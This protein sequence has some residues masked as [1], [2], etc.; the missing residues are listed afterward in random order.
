MKLW[1]NYILA[2]SVAEAVQALAE[3]GGN[4]KPVAGGTDLLLELQQGRQNPV[5]T[6]VDVSAI[7]DLQRLEVRGAQLFVGAGVPVARI[8]EHPL[9]R[10]HAPA[11]VEACGLIGGPQ[12]RNTATLGGNVA[13]ALPAADGMIALAAM[14]AVAEVAGPGTLRLVPLLQLFRGLGKNVLTENHEILV[15][16]YL[17]LRQKGNASVFSRIMRPQGVALPILNMAI[18][19]Q[20]SGGMIDCIRLAVGP[21]GPTP[22]RALAVEEFLY[23]QPYTPAIVDQAVDLIRSSLKF[24]TNPRRATAEYRQHLVGVLLIEVLEKAWQRA[25]ELE[26]I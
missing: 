23:R 7:P 26:A 12:V 19:L 2:A 14:D 22:Q 1:S 8:V 20:R 5:H 24:R 25:S 15:G 11:V 10:L 9:M 3:G 6:L 17:P 16:F 21:A 18:W 4:A 13:H